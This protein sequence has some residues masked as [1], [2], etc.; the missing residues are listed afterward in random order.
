VVAGYAREGELVTTRKP[1]ARRVSIP[2]IRFHALVNAASRIGCFCADPVHREHEGKCIGCWALA[3]R[4]EHIRDLLAHTTSPA[5]SMI[6]EE[7]QAEQRLRAEGLPAAERRLAK[8]RAEDTD[9][10][11]EQMLNDGEA[12]T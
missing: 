1:S 12:E 5:L 10:D 7:C 4:V 6:L 8:A 3:Q 2:T 11:T 9:S